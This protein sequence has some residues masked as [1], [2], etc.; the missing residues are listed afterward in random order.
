MLLKWNKDNS[1]VLHFIIDEK[2]KLT[3]EYA[4]LLPGVNEIADAEFE[5]CKASLQDVIAAGTLE[6]LDIKTHT[7]PGKPQKVASS[8]TD[9]APSKADALIKET[10]SGETLNLWLAKDVRDGVRAR[11]RDR[12]KF[13]KID[14][15]DVP[16]RDDDF[17][18]EEDAPK[19]GKE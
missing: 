2:S 5:N 15:V 8:I 9:L 16:L 11:I 1:K 18:V 14:E 19:K 17:E 3:R 6:V 12:L 10:Y 13:L 4:T 7:A